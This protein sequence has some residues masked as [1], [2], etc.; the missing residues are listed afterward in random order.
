MR[1]LWI[2]ML[3]LMSTTMGTQV[4]LNQST[5]QSNYVDANQNGICD[6]REGHSNH[7]Q[8]CIFVDEDHDGICD[9]YNNRQSI[10]HTGQHK[11]KHRGLHS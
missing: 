1:K 11:M 5:S 9:Y 4:P 7:K 6:H 10:H 3:T 8:D 2:M